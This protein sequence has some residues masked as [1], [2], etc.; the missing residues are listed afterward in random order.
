M[1]QPLQGKFIRGMTLVEVLVGSA[2][3]VLIAVTVYGA[4]NNIFNLV[5]ASRQKT[6]ATLL[7]NEEFEIIHNLPY[8][9]VGTVGG[10]PTGKI[11]QT[12][13]LTR[14]GIPF[15]VN[16]SIYSLDD[17]FDGTIGGTPND[18]SPADYKLVEVDISC[19]TCSNFNP[20]VFTGRVAPKN[21]ESATTNGALFVQAFDAN[22]L[23]IAGANVH[24]VNNSIIPPVDITDSTNNAG[25]FQIVDA[26][27][28]VEGYQITVNKTGYSE[29]S[30]TMRSVST[31]PHPVIPY[32][33]VA[34]QEVTSLS[35]AID[36]VSSLAVTSVT[37]ICVPVPAIDYFLSGTKLTGTNPSIVKFSRNLVTDAGG[38]QNLN[39]LEWDNYNITVTDPAYDLVG[40]NPLFPLNLLPNS[41]QS[42]QLVV[43]PA[44]SETLLVAVKDGATGLPIS[45]ANVTLTESG[46]STILGTGEGYL[47]QT[48]WS[49]GS[50]Q[51]T[52]IDSTKYFSG[53][54]DIIDA[55]PA[56]VLHLRLVAG[57]YQSS[58]TLESSTFDVGSASNFHE[59]T[60]APISQ[61]SQT[62]VSAVKFQIATNNDNATWNYLGP[63]GT[64]STY[65][66]ASNT[67]INAIHN[68]TRYFR[69]R[70][71]LSTADPTYTPTISDVSF[72]FSS[73]CTPPGQ[74]AFQGLTSGVYAITV[75]KSGYTDYSGS[76]TASSSW[77]QLGITLTP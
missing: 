18:L 15:T 16:T 77:Q 24:V 55:I 59:L 62:G 25:L 70:L 47:T 76:I 32:A 57:A 40:I 6:A 73:A 7:A 56:G 66:T 67:T 31:N 39:N 9:D 34:T 44:K 53:G 30:T 27:P 54:V 72:T 49:G 10:L 5:R 28:Y 4:F 21:L 51:N 68:G 17:P 35:F 29:S 71:T 58:A 64:A 52:F 60:W 48:D 2:V 1:K 41:N 14:A 33:T 74:V 75:Q 50:G 3:F 45:G 36:K 37:D 8:S 42:L 22:G 38:I 43:A 23:P 12:Q 46:I 19:S 13:T 63:D 26:P 65:Y 69:Y 11:L 61:P 20:L